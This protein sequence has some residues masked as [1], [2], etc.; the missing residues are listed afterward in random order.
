MR[1]SK[2]LLNLLIHISHK[3]FRAVKDRIVVGQDAL[4]ALRSSLGKVATAVRNLLNVPSALEGMLG[5]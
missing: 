3:L 1:Q 4:E 2:K 5:E